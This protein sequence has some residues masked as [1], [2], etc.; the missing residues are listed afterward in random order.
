MTTPLENR[1]RVGVLGPGPSPRPL[2]SK[3]A[4]GPETPIS[5]ASATWPEDL[6]ERVAA[7][8]QP[9]TTYTNYAEMLADPNIDAVIV[10]IA[11]QFHVDAA[12]QALAA[13]KHVL[14]EKPMGVDVAG[15]L[16][17]RDAT[18]ASGL[19]LQVGSMKRFDPG[20]V[21]ARRFIT[22]EI[23]SCSPSRP[24]TPTRPTATPP[25]PTSSRSS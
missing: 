6:L 19:S 21:A 17:L 13:G 9:H 18:A 11:D 23:A 7:I 3:P 12:V 16:R 1:L 22:E 25:P 4:D 15:A 24:G 8:H 5:S 14:V 20:I 10:A 2:T